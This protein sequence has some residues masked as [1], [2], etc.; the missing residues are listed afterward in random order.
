MDIGR[1][2][3]EGVKV[4]DNQLTWQFALNAYNANYTDKPHVT[5]L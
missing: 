1:G 4:R 3:G 2:H 5:Y